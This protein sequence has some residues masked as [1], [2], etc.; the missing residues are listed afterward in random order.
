M[1]FFRSRALFGGREPRAGAAVAAATQYF[2]GSGTSLD[3]KYRNYTEKEGLAKIKGRGRRS[4]LRCDERNFREKKKYEEENPRYLRPFQAESQSLK[5]QLGNRSLPTDA[6]HHL[7]AIFETTNDNNAVANVAGHF[8]NK[9]CEQD[10]SWPWNTWLGLP[11]KNVSI[12][13]IIFIYFNS[14]VGGPP[15]AHSVCCCYIVE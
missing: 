5:N 14:F 10:R 4:P 9:A 15:Y 7:P 8:S 3:H 2:Y 12:I 1:V 11:I 6:N 13:L